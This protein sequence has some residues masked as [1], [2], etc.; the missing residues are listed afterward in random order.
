MTQEHVWSAWVGRLFPYK[1]VRF[2]RRTGDGEWKTWTSHAVN[3]TAGDVCGICNNG[4]M[5][6]L[7]SAVKDVMADMIVQ[8]KETDL[9]P[10]SIAPIAAFA[11]KTAILMDSMSGAKTSFFTAKSRRLFARNLQFPADTQVLIFLAN[12]ANASQHG[13]GTVL[14]DRGSTVLR[15]PDGS[16]AELSLKY[17]ISTWTAGQIVIQVLAV[18]P[19]RPR[20]I[21]RDIVFGI[22][23]NEDFKAETVQI[24][25]IPLQAGRWPCSLSLDNQSLQRFI[26][27]WNPITIAGRKA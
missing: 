14:Y 27:R 8:G 22:F 25:P 19:R 18:K 11:L 21:P 9:T 4:W 7:E 17:S 16:K 13:A 5:S 1:R 3:M 15:S 10:K 2:K 20:A 23:P 26:N 6:Q 24:W 12:L